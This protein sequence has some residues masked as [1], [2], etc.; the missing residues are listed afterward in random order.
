MMSQRKNFSYI[1]PNKHDYIT[2]VVQ[3]AHASTLHGGA[4]LT[5]DFIRK[6]FWIIDG[7]NAVRSVTHKCMV[8]F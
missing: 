1:L 3:N 7:R 5:L 4:A 6:R 2:L 8:C